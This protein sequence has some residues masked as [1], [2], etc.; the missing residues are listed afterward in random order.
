MINGYSLEYDDR[1]KIEDRLLEY[2]HKNPES[3]IENLKNSFM[4]VP[5]YSIVRVENVY[6]ERDNLY[7]CHVKWHK[8][9]MCAI[10]VLP[11]PEGFLRQMK[12]ERI[13]K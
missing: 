12:L 13:L 6:L 2:L 10:S 9:L 7:E 8:D 5:D 1:V 11:I 4:N 3:V